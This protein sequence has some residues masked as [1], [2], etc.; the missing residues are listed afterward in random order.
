MTTPMTDPSGPGRNPA[1][2]PVQGPE[3]SFGPIP[4]ADVG[5]SLAGARAIGLLE[6]LCPVSD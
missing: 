3:L 4:A 5:R 1:W 6:T 2:N